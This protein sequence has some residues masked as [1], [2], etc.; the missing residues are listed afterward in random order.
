[1]IAHRA[2]LNVVDGCEK[3]LKFRES[4]FTMSVNHEC[5]FSEPAVFRSFSRGWNTQHTASDEEFFMLPSWTN[6][7]A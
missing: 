6:H 5:R 1:M 3:P 2:D 4:L 7:V